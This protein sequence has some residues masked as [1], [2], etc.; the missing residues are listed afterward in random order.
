[1]WLWWVVACGA[2]QRDS[3]TDNPVTVVPTS[4]PEPAA[5]PT[6]PAVPPVTPPPPAPMV[7]GATADPKSAYARLRTRVEEPEKAGECKVDADCARAG[8]GSEVCTATASVSS[9]VTTCE[10]LPLF[11]ALDACGCHEGSCTW[12]LKAAPLGLQPITLPGDLP[13]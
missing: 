11:S 6:D 12:T 1:M 9:V 2:P 10:V 13:Q 8:C 3:V 4:P 7:D 5:T